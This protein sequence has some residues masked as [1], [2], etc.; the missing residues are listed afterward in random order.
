MPLKNKFTDLDNTRQPHS[1]FEI[2]LYNIRQ[3]QF[4]FTDME[5]GI[6]KTSI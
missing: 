4:I 1:L 5:S 3:F 6:F 2:K